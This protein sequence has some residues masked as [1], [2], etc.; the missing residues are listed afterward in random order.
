MNRK[1]LVL[2]FAAGLGAAAVGPLS[3][4]PGSET[5]APD[6]AAIYYRQVYEIYANRDATQEQLSLAI[7]L[8]E[9]AQSLTPDN[10]DYAFT[11]G[12]LHYRLRQWQEA[13]RWYGKA[14][15][16]APDSTARK[17]AEV[18]RKRTRE[19]ILQAQIAAREAE[20]P[21]LS[22]SVS[23]SLKSAY[24]AKKADKPHIEDKALPT[25]PVGQSPQPIIQAIEQALPGYRALAQDGFVIAGT[26]SPETLQR[27][28]QRGVVDFYN[29]FRSR[30]FPEP[31]QNHLVLLLA[32]DPYPLV[33]AARRLYPNYEFHLDAPF[34]GYF[35]PIDNLIIA[36]I[37]GG[38]GTLLHEMMH[39]MIASDFPGCPG[40]LEEGMATLYERSAWEASQLEPLPN[41]RMHFV[42]NSRFR[43]LAELDTLVQHPKLENDELAYVRLLMLFLHEHGRLADFYNQAKIRGSDFSLAAV[44][45]DFGAPF[46]EKNWQ[47]FVQQT[48]EEYRL[49]LL[50]DQN[51][52]TP[53]EALFVQRA[54]N[55]ILDA[56]L[57][58]D[59]IWGPASQAKLEAFQRR[60]GLTPDGVLG[61][62]TWSS[63]EREFTLRALKR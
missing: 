17:N 2:V 24:L 42:E 48:L 33:Q 52:L 31:P 34:V 57:S 10:Y 16:L 30:Y 27:H 63:L 55:L 50:L 38:Y 23:F 61:P 11:L 3:A 56:G 46:T 53:K 60:F 45:A 35:I 58:E 5:A 6:S 37:G 59:G 39:A 9:R 43:S 49:E 1:A 22:Y 44:L 25:I 14:V 47:D 54:L 15:D 36:T 4:Q 20:G 41:W 26:D 28:Y 19:K 62:K 29:V 18:Y 13:A 8:A 7:A 21:S 12:A 40:W 51:K 32:D